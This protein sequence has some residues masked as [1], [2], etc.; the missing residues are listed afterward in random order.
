MKNAINTLRTFRTN[1]IVPGKTTNRLFR[2]VLTLFAFLGLAIQAYSQPATSAATPALPQGRVISLWNSSG[3]YTNVAVQNYFEVWYA[4]DPYFYTMPDTGS[5]VLLY[6]DMSCCAAIATGTNP[7]VNASG[8]TNLHLD[9]YTP[10]GNN[11]KIRL[12]DTSN[13][14]G[15][16]LYSVAGGVITNNGWIG[17][18]IPLALFTSDNPLLNL[19]SIKQIGWIDSEGGGGEVLPASYYIDNVYFNA[20]TNLVFTPPPVIPVPTNNAPTPTNSPALSLY[21]SSGTYTDVTASEWPTFWS[22]SASTSFVITNPPGSTVK[23]M[24][25]LS[26]V[27]VQYPPN[28]INTAGYDT[29]HFD[30][31]TLDGN[32]LA[33][34][35]VSLSPTAAAQVMSS[36]GVTQQWVSVNIPLSQ[37]AS[38]NP[39][40]ILTNI[41]QV[42]FVDNIGPGIQNATFYIDNVYFYSNSVVTPPP[43]A[44]TNN[45]VANWNFE[46]NAATS[47]GLASWETAG[48][49]GAI[50][51]PVTINTTDP[52]AGLQAISIEGQGTGV[53]A[54]PTFYQNNIPVAPGTLTLSFYAK[55]VIKD[56]GASPQ[57]QISW[58]NAANAQIS[59]TAFTPWPTALNTSTYTLQTIS[60]LTAPAGSDHCTITMLLAV[61]AGT[62]DHWKVLVDNLTLV[63]NTIVAPS[64]VIDYPTNAPANPTPAQANVVSLYNSS[65]NYTNVNIDTWLTGWSQ[66]SYTPYLITNATR[67]VKRY[68]SLN[69]AG[70]EF[71]NPKINASG[72]TT[73]HVD[74][75]TPNA[76]KFSVKL[77]SFAPGAAE[78]EVVFTNNVIVTNQWVSLDIPISTFTSGNPAMSF[79]NLGQLLFI[80][81]NPGGPQYGTFYIDNVYFYTSAVTPTS[82][83]ITAPAVSGGNFTLQVNSQTGYNYV[84]Q[85]TPSLA[86][87]SWTNIQ[88]N[89]GT[90][91]VLN[92]S[93][94]VS[95]GNPQQ[96]YRVNV[97]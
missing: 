20:S 84:L 3:T 72:M 46:T 21:N 82:P 5:N 57:Y 33:I 64:T 17:L 81:N 63:Q 95:S 54:G 15:N 67:T 39:A 80:N 59:A 43:P 78:Y 50:G 29:L 74:L 38:A 7:P 25:G 8:C 2:L 9:L 40:T 79:A 42:L 6:A 83:T 4:A 68:S 14:A 55:A 31:W 34:Q 96:F 65:G 76:S 86:P 71:F 85:A 56:G 47:T 91:G 90:G 48:S 27:G 69:Y 10:T 97:Q 19:A 49:G 16:V 22:G 73:F 30:V 52:Y 24:P 12:V 70:V 18:D 93:V 92:F 35:L 11:L 45:L 32:Q 62:G 88:T 41:E 89:A 75:W 51:T 87:A 44:V 28:S 36:I 94:P 53:G 1:Q 23:Y 37:F 66:A 13:R 61:G 60:G 77:V 58:R 26:Y